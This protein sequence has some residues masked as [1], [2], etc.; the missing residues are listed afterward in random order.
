MENLGTLATGPDPAQR[1]YYEPLHH[2]RQNELAAL[3]RNRQQAESRAAQLGLLQNQLYRT[4]M[5][6]R[7]GCGVDSHPS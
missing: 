2:Q 4:A 7:W 6:C 1:A 3:I 5:K